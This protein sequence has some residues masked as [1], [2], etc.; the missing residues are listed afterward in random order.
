[1]SPPTLVDHLLAVV[2]GAVLP[3]AGVLRRAPLRGESLD[4][5]ERVA[6]AWNGAAAL[7]VMG[8]TVLAAWWWREGGFAG[9]GLT[10]APAL[11]TPGTRSAALG[12]TAGF[13]LLYAAHLT[14]HLATPARRAATRARWERDT[15]FMPR[16]A[17]ELPHFAVLS[18]AAG[19]FEELVFRGFLVSYLLLFTG[20]DLAWLAVALPAVAFGLAHL[21]QGAGAA[22]F[23][24]LMACLF[25]ALFLATGSLWIGIVLHAGVDLL[26]ALLGVRMLLDSGGDGSV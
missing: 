4:R 24:A 19:V 18:V 14:W 17:G 9:L 12:L 6:V 11:G 25:G 16:T 7:A 26:A 21:Y 20:P 8:A 3:L 5:D 2:Y 1:V 10:E 22:A 23:V 13:L 15:P